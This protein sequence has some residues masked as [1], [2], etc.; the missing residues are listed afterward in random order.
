MAHPGEAFEAIYASMLHPV[1]ERLCAVWEAATGEPA[2]SETTKLTVFSMIGQLI[3]FRIGRPA[4]TRRLGMVEYGDAGVKA[5]VEVL[6]QNV[7]ARLNM[8]ERES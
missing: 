4:I 8:K 2:E 1:H 3:Y 6:V 5:I 7:S